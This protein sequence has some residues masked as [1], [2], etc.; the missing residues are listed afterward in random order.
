M[1]EEGCVEGEA[2]MSLGIATSSAGGG[3]HSHDTKTHPYL[4]LFLEL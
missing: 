4:E 1:I 2:E 3:R